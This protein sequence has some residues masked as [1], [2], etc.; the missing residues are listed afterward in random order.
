VREREFHPRNEGVVGVFRTRPEAERAIDALL[1]SGFTRNQ[2]SVLMRGKEESEQFARDTGIKETHAAEGAGTGAGIG[3]VA[4]GAAGILAGLGLLAIPGIGPLLAAGPIAAGL[5]GAVAGGAAGGVI[6]ALVGLG[7]P[8]TEAKRYEGEVKQ[9]HILVTVQCDGQCDRASSLLTS[10]A[11]YDVRNYSG[12]RAGVVEAPERERP[13]E[14]E[15]Y[16]QG[17]RI[18]IREEELRAQKQH[19]QT[20]EVEIG[21]EV[22]EEERTMRVPVTH[23]EVEV[24][25]HPTDRPA[26]GDMESK[27]YRVPIHEEE[28]TVEKHPRVKEELEIK[29]RQVT[30]E[31]EVKGKVRK[32]VPHIEKG[33]TNEEEHRR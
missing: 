27:S 20:G 12:G 26:E 30:E 29:K 24:T 31:K 9:G 15:R 22:V 28:V 7:I 32:E 13:M 23:E 33:P 10:Y 11:A 25:R 18:P 4:G 5:G 19:R 8:E 6:G 2:I 3:A 16:E 21:K 14:R 1:N 17:G